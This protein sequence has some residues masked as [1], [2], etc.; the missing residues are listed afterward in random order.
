MCIFGM[1]YTGDTRESE[2][3]SV[4]SEEESRDSGLLAIVVR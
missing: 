1:C 3:I 4:P 2:S